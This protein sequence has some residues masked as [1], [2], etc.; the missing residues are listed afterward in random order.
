MGGVTYLT[1]SQHN[2]LD[3]QVIHGRIQA[4]TFVY[5][6]FEVKN[7]NWKLI[8]ERAT[9]VAI[10]SVLLYLL[11]RLEIALVLALFEYA[12]LV[13]IAFVAYPI[14]EC[15]VQDHIRYSRLRKGRSHS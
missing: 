9:I 4:C 2:I 14:L 12:P 8:L 11:V 10:G 13:L 3:K 5:R 15:E 6:E 1:L 7:L